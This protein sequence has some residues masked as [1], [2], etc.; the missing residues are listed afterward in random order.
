MDLIE[1]MRHMPGCREYESTPVSDEVLY[2]VLDNA[3]FAPSGGNRQ[4]WKVVVIR[5]E[6]MREALRDQYRRTWDRYVTEMYG[7]AET[8][9]E[10]VRVALDDAARMADQLHTIPVHLA[11]WVDM[12]AIAVT[13]R[14]APRPSVVAGGS[15]FPFIQNIQ[16]AAR[17]EGLGTRITTLLSYDEEPVRQMLNV[18][19]GYALAAVLLVG[20]PA[21]LPTKLRRHPVEKFAA[22]ETF[23]GL[24]LHL[25]SQ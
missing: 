13:D 5:D 22:C 24:P 8:H 17:N 10:K 12:A 1:A 4:G 2:R 20:W 18:P 14:D 15:I 25:P 9:S 6:A 23:D 11:I 16:L 19:N 21:F 7:P 3:R